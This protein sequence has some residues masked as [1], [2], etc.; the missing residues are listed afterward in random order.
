[1]SNKSVL[2]WELSSRA[3]FVYD[4]LECQAIKDEYPIANE[5]DTFF[6]ISDNGEYTKIWG[7]F[8]TLPLTDTQASKD[9]CHLPATLSPL[10]RE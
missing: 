8:G 2:V 10:S 6:V 3:V 1:M 5:Y 7:I 9:L 4:S